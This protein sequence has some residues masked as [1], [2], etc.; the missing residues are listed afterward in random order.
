MLL[1]VGKQICDGLRDTTYRM[2]AE[3][4][5]SAVAASKALGKEEG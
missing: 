4:G 3:Y 1:S 2:S 5:I